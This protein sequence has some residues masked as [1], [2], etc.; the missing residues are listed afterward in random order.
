MK[1]IKTI[2]II[3]TWLIIISASC[4]WNFSL[5]EKNMKLVVKSQAQSFF[6]QIQITRSWNALHGSVYVPIT[7]STQPNPFLEDSLREIY[8]DS[9]GIAL[10]KIN[11]AYMTRQISDIAEKENN[12]KFHITSLK[13]IRPQNKADKWETIQLQ[14]FENG[15]SEYMEYIDKDSTYRYMGALIVENSCMQCHEKQGYKVGDTRGGISVTIQGENYKEAIFTQKRGVF[16]FHFFI[17]II[18]AVSIL[19]FLNYSEKQFEKLQNEKKIIQKKNIELKEN[20]DKLQELNNIKDKFFTIIAHDLKNPVSTL[21]GFSELLINNFDTYNTEK[22]KKVL[23]YM[24]ESIQST[25][26]LLNNLLQWSIAQKGNIVFNPKLINLFSISDKTHKLLNSSAEIKAIKLLNKIPENIFVK[27]DK[28]MLSTIFRNLIS[29]AVKFTPKGGVV[30]TNAKIISSNDKKYV[31]ISVKDN[32]IGITPERQSKLFS[33]R[34]NTTTKGTDNE[35]GTGIG[36]VLCKEFVEKHNGKIW[37]ESE[38]G[39]GSRFVFTIPE[40]AR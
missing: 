37:I 39:K 8:I 6:N 29:N 15:T 7:D 10:T 12:I 33:I 11:P 5:I 20:K 38:S 32:G 35:A 24:H 14:K 22:Q 27:A 2:L 23:G 21:I 4:I 26:K 1:Q 17:F 18:G 40:A 16:I 28:D 9:L 30:E 25:Y 34:E 19:L 13:P 31:E 36:L 3:I